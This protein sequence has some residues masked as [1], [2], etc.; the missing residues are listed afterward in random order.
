MVFR[1]SWAV[2]RA[3][4]KRTRIAKMAKQET[5]TWWRDNVLA[6]RLE[7]LDRF[8]NCEPLSQEDQRW[9]DIFL[10]E[11]DSWDIADYGH[12]LG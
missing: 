1:D 10:H 2:E 12:Q 9:L 11:A 5:D 6:A 3:R 7:L 8:L 4:L